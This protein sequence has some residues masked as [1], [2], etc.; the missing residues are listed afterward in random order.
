LRPA[1]PPRVCIRKKPV[2]WFITRSVSKAVRQV[3]FVSVGHGAAGPHPTLEFFRFGVGWG[4]APPKAMLNRTYGLPHHPG[5]AFAKNQLL[6][7][8]PAVSV[9]RFVSWLLFQLGMVRQGRT[10]HSTLFRFGVGW[11]H[12]PPKVM[13]NRTVR[14]RRSFSNSTS[15]EFLFKL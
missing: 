13:L 6:G 15:K 14:H 12:A 1:A 8:L 9:K 4:H 7:S 3:A 10:L 5:Y 2:T 11:G